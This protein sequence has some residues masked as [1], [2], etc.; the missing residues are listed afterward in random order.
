MRKINSETLQQRQ[1]TQSTSSCPGSLDGGSTPILPRHDARKPL[2]KAAP[3]CFANHGCGQSA[4]PNI[5]SLWCQLE[6]DITEIR[7]RH[8]RDMTE[9]RPRYDRDKT[10][11][12]PKHDRDIS[13]TS[14]RQCEARRGLTYRKSRSCLGHVSVVSR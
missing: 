4:V 7:S 14:P 1:S 3:L 10:A 5:C 2:C 6:R 8:D 12:R 13:G 9:T 11:T